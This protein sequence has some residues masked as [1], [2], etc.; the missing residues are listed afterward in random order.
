MPSTQGASGNRDAFPRWYGCFRTS[1]APLSSPGG[2][3]W[4]SRRCQC[5]SGFLNSPALTPSNTPDGDTSVLKDG[6]TWLTTPLWHENGALSKP[7]ENAG[8]SGL[9]SFSRGPIPP[10]TLL[11][12]SVC[13]PNPLHDRVLHPHSWG[14][15]DWGCCLP[16]C[17]P[18]RTT[19]TLLIH[20]VGPFPRVAAAL[21][22]E[23]RQTGGYASLLRCRQSIHRSR[24]TPRTVTG[25]IPVGQHPSGRLSACPTTSILFVRKNGEN[26]HHHLT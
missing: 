23:V 1:S 22:V 14:L 19:R 21:G 12:W 7:E 17:L 2:L 18:H 13:S 4:S 10:A 15:C 8:L 20:L 26:S 25:C 6:A 24:P 5:W 9:L 3:W 16:A 11:A